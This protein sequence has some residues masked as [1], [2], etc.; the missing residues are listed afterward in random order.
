MNVPDSDHGEELAFI[1]G[2]EQ[3]TNLY[4]QR[5]SDVFNAGTNS[6]DPYPTTVTSRSS[7]DNS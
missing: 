4:A 5:I 6:L 2:V 3:S 1:M 7:L